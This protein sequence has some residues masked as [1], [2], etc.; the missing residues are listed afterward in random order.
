MLFGKRGKSGLVGLN[1]DFAQVI[2]FVKERLGKE[3][4]FTSYIT[5]YLYFY[6]LYLTLINLRVRLYVSCR[7]KW[8]DVK[9]LLQRSSLN[10]SSLTMKSS[11]LTLSLSDLVPALAFQSVEELKLKRTGIRYCKIN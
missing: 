1:L 6:S 5:F 4:H 10:L 11:T 9:D 2:A 3:V 7:W 8:V